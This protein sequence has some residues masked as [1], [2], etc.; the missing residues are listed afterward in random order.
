MRE[1]PGLHARNGN[2]GAAT[3]RLRAKG[4]VV[5]L[6]VDEGAR[7]AHEVGTLDAGAERVARLLGLM[8]A[9]DGK[10]LPDVVD[11]YYIPSST[12]ERA[13]AA[14]LSIASSW[15]LWGGVVPQRF[16]STKV[17]S[18]PLWREDAVAP[19]GWKAIR[20][21]GSWTLPG[22]SVFARE[23][24]RAAGRALLR[25]GGIRFK[26]PCARGGMG[27]QPIADTSSLDAWIDAADDA[28]FVAGL[29][30]ERD[31]SET[32]TYSVGASKLRNERIAYHGEQR[33]VPDHGGNLVYGGS[34]LRVRR[35]KLE[36]LHAGL[37]PG[38]LADAV[39]LATAYDRAVRAAY[40]VLATRC[41]YDVIAGRDGE[42]RRRIGVLE[43]SWRFGGA[44]MAEL[45][46]LERFRQCPG[47]DA[48]VAETVECWDGGDV[49]VDAVVHWRGDRDSPCK[50]ARIVRDG[51]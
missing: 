18:H 39:G 7:A 30:I 1:Q 20:G 33:V 47:L 51:H 50:Y 8:H 25:D 15:Q 38:E 21:I 48:L 36:E 37:D 9:R 40:G 35:G 11:R 6:D 24:A 22:Y 17:V 31:L 16:V 41:N 44:S 27:Q 13:Q 12:L 32:T 14:A 28:A 4:F 23:D 2:A 10:Q 46:A 43:Q 29:V 49:P 45:L 5:A 26:C 42:G 3:R 19:A 34:R